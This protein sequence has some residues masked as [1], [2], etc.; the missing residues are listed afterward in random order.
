MI[1]TLLLITY[2]PGISMLIPNLFGRYSQRFA[3]GPPEARVRM[4][5]PHPF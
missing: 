3:L 1:V 4:S 5:Y 2:I